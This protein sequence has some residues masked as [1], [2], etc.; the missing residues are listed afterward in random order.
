MASIGSILKKVALILV[1]PVIA[2]VLIAANIFNKEKVCTNIT[3]NVVNANAYSV[4]NTQELKDVL[5]KSKN[6]TIGTTKIKEV[7]LKQLE[8]IANNYPW[9]KDANIY[10]DS[11][12]VLHVDVKQRVPIVRWVN[13]NGMQQYLDEDAKSIPITNNIVANIP[14]V[15]TIT[16]GVNIADQNLMQQLVY[17]GKIIKED[18]FWNAA[19]TQIDYDAKSKFQLYSNVSNSNIIFGD[20]SMAKDKLARLM[21]FYKNAANKVGWNYYKT[22]SL[23]NNGQLVATKSDAVVAV[24]TTVPTTVK[25]TL[26]PR[27]LAAKANSNNAT[28]AKSKKVLPINKI[29]SSSNKQI[30]NTSKPIKV[31]NKPAITSNKKLQK[32]F[33]STKS[34]SQ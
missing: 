19:I 26:T 32:P 28:L 9:V 1:V 17:L 33:N 4:F 15:T 7:D 13:G 10:W 31:N 11:K 29:V 3:V 12:E 18:T 5:I 27:A 2:G 8:D 22:L 6:I 24:N 21:L 23:I 25:T 30:I 16:L 20:T 14:I 34:K